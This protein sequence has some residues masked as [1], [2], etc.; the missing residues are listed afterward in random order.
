MPCREAGVRNLKNKL[1]RIYRKAARTLVER[2]VGGPPPSPQGTS[3]AAL[4]AEPQA[5]ASQEPP[6]PDTPPQTPRGPAGSTLEDLT[7]A[8]GVPESN[9]PG[10]SP[11]TAEVR[12]GYSKQE[13]AFSQHDVHQAV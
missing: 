12:L 3:G 5:A 8:A 4:E 2:G 11:R 9:A 10:A 13:P 6:A 7:P 1:E